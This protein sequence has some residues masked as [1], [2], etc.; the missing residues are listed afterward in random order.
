MPFHRFE[1]LESSYLTPHLST[2]KAPVIEGQYMYFC[3]LHK[4]AR[5]GASSA[6]A[7]SCMRRPMRVTR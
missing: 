3:L 5:I 7:P 4:D 1:Q 2:G 6:P